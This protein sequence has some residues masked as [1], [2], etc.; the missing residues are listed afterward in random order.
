MMDYYSDFPAPPEDEVIRDVTKELLKILGDT[1]HKETVIEKCVKEVLY[2]LGGLSALGS[3]T[4][5]YVLTRNNLIESSLKKMK[6]YKARYLKFKTVVKMTI[7]LDRLYDDVLHNRYK[8]EGQ[9]YIEAKQDFT[10][11][12]TTTKG[13]Y[14]D[15]S[16]PP[17]GDKRIDR[18]IKDSC[19]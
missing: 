15:E 16:L 17:I 7:A 8:P 12:Q 11:H 2:E 3:Y 19:K 6:T 18:P 9:G 1:S 10:D 4:G 13:T 5:Y 14:I